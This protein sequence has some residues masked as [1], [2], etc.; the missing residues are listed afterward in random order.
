MWIKRDSLEPKFL[1]T[2]YVKNEAEMLSFDSW[3]AS[4]LYSEFGEL[5]HK[6]SFDERIRKNARVNTSVLAPFLSG[7]R[8]IGDE[9]DYGNPAGLCSQRKP[10]SRR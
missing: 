1:L 9:R 3:V 6:I 8:S 2:S 10:S 5:F 4:N 7:I